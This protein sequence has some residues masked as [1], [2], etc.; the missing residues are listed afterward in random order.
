MHA[1]RRGSLTLGAGVIVATLAALGAVWWTRPPSNLIATAQILGPLPVRSRL[2]SLVQVDLDGG[3]PL[4]AAAI[5]MIPPFPGEGASA[6]TEII[7]QHNRWRR[8]FEIVFQR[9]LSGMVPVSVDAG[10]ILGNRDGVLFQGVTDEGRWSFH[11][12]GQA[13]GRIVVLTEGDSLE[14]VTLADPLVIDRGSG[15]ALEWNDERFVPR[16]LPAFTTPPAGLTW[17]SAMRSGVVM[18]RTSRLVLALRQTL[19]LHRVGGGT[20]PIV[21]ADPHLDV[22]ENGFRARQP[23]TYSIR[24]LSPFTLTEEVYVLTVIVSDTTP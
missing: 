3:A 11:V 21:V 14:R 6:Y 5:V 22:V 9:P 15:Q 13:T 24:L 2:H 23:G 17:R 8:R 19:R 4:E 1:G 20:T 10:R 18:A 7:V 16:P 12:V